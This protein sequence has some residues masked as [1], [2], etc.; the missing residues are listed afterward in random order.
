MR[1]MLLIVL[2]T[3]I[4]VGSA[5]P[6]AVAALQWQTVCPADEPHARWVVQQY[7]ADADLRA[8]YGIGEITSSDPRPL[9]DSTDGPVCQYFAE[10]V[11]GSSQQSDIVPK[12][13]YYQAGGFYWI[14]GVPFTTSGTPA[15]GGGGA[16]FLF[17][18]DKS[19]RATFAL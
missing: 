5:T 12:W 17:G 4:S 19:H 1:K 11:R 6:K 7:L 13:V 9:A 18:P 10:L 3:L 2:L 8:Q 15:L 16:L 14:V